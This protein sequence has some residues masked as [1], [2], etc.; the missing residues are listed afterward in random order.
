MKFRYKKLPTSR[1]KHIPIPLI[2]VGI[3]IP[4][5][6]GM[7]FYNC[8][9]DSGAD[10]TYFHGDVGRSLGL[11]IEEGEPSTG[12][13]IAGQT[14]IAY[15]HKVI[16]N[17]GGTDIKDFI[18]LSDDLGTPFGILGRQGFFDHFKVCFEQKKEM[19]EIK[20]Y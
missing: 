19:V 12:R 7:I 1:G 18:Y 11:K 3:K 2:D 17:I 4:K 20:P 8:L 6:L 15:K 13:G 10:Q 16:Y 5:R 9:I 14:F